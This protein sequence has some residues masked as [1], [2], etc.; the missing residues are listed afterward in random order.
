MELRTLKAV[1]DSSE[2]C[3]RT[4]LLPLCLEWRAFVNMGNQQSTHP[5]T[6]RHGGTRGGDAPPRSPR[7]L[8]PRKRRRTAE[9]LCSLKVKMTPRTLRRRLTKPVAV[10]SGGSLLEEKHRRRAEFKAAQAK[11]QHS[12]D[13]DTDSSEYDNDSAHGASPESLE[14]T[15]VQR[16]MGKI[17]EV[18]EIIRRVS[19]TSSR[20][21]REGSEAELLP[22]LQA[23]VQDMNHSLHQVL[24]MEEAAPRDSPSSLPPC[25]PE[26]TTPLLPGRPQIAD[27]SEDPAV[28]HAWLPR[29]PGS[30]GEPLLSGES[31]AG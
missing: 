22:E 16:V 14:E 27:T 24:R 2:T 12:L 30:C 5:K 19:L 26:S 20:W 1:G 28:R 21:M 4:E 18:E 31:V 17:E 29:G 8:I 9:G 3:W 23:L 13:S 25:L 10:P 15:A 7:S 6:E 11:D